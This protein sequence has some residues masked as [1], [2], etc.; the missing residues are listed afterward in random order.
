MS[1]HGNIGPFE[2]KR[3][4]FANHGR[5]WDP[6]LEEEMTRGI[7]PDLKI[8]QKKNQRYVDKLESSD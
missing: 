8:P 5:R 3:N 4:P 2:K 1:G 7:I 6:E